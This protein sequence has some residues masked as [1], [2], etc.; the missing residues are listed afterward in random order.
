[1]YSAVWWRRWRA[2]Y[3]EA[4]KIRTQLMLYDALCYA[5]EYNEAVPVCEKGDWPVDEILSNMARD[6][7]ISPVFTIVLY[8][9]AQPWDGPKSLREMLE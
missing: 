2:W 9:G 8:Y 6:T 1:M 7:K 4:G 5:A 3:K